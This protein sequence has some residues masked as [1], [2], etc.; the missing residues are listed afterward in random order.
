MIK[1]LE[2][3]CKIPENVGWMLVGV[4]GTLCVIMAVKLGKLFV[5]MWKEWHEPDE[6]EC[7]E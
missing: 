1:M 5:Q 4:V 2:L 7:E 6:E 3:L